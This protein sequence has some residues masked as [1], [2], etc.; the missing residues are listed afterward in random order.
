MEGHFDSRYLKPKQ[1]KP[2]DIDKLLEEAN[3]IN[4]K[5]YHKDALSN[6]RIDD[7]PLQD[8][9]N[10]EIVERDWYKLYPVDEIEDHENNYHDPQELLPIDIPPMNYQYPSQ[11]EYSNFNNTKQ[12]HLKQDYKHPPVH[13]ITQNEDEFDTSERIPINKT[14]KSKNWLKR[15]LGL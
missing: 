2:E 15:W 4:N 10:E 11:S 7:D 1:H 13:E 8:F 12:L 14:Y 6:T 3:S 5:T 9:R